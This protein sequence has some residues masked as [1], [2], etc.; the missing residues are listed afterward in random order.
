MSTV[1]D[2]PISDETRLAALD[3]AVADLEAEGWHSDPKRDNERVLV[4]HNEFRRLLVRAR[5]PLGTRRELVEVDKHG[6]ISIT[7]V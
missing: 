4:G 5:R 1:Q 2:L 3:R 6:Q 7:S